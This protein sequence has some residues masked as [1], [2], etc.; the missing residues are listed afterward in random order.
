MLAA[1]GFLG[2]TVLFVM[3]FSRRRLL[4]YGVVFVTVQIAV[5]TVQGFSH[6]VFGVLDYSEQAFLG[7]V[8]LYDYLLSEDVLLTPDD[9]KPGAQ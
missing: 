5:W 8:L 2:G 3:D 1:T 6:G 7:V 4:L 9:R